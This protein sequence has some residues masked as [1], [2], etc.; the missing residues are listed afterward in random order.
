MKRAIFLSVP[1]TVLALLSACGGDQ[2]AGGSAKMGTP[3]Y[4]WSGAKQTFSA[5]DY[6][7]TNDHLTELIRTENPYRDR[8]VPWR[9]IVLSAMAKGYSELRENLEFGGRA[10]R[11]AAFRRF[12]ND[13]RQLASRNALEFAESFE[14]FEKA[15]T[16]KTVLLEFPFPSG[17][18]GMPRELAVLAKGETPDQAKVDAG[19]KRSVEREVLLLTCHALG[20]GEDVAKAQQ[21]LQGGKAEVPRETFMMAMASALYDH[22]KLFTPMKLN[23]PDRVEFF[24]THS[25]EAL[26][27]VP[28]SKERKALLA[29]LDTQL[30]EAKKLMGKK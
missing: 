19:R 12:M 17:N 10:N 25:R 18:V 6:A 4:F 3:E 16:G 1:T 15:H 26:D 28:D 23:L 20:A 9:L 8:A 13:A 5:K 14:K 22:S 21:L 30:K 2:Q 11:G 7:K 29:K 24:N 27:S